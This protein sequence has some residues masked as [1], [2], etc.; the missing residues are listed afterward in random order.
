VSVSLAACKGSPAPPT[1]DVP[2]QDT[3]D[4]G[5][6]FDPDEV[7]PSAAFTDFQA[8]STSDVQGF[9]EHNPYNGGS[10]LSTYQS[11]GVLFS[12]AVT[13]AA[14]TYR[15]NP[16]VLLVAV[17]AEGALVAD[18]A[19]P[20]G[21]VLVD[22][23]FGCGCG[24]PSVASTCAPSAAGLDVQLACYADALRTSLD[25]IA[26]TGQTTGGWGPGKSAT[27][28]DG[29]T[30]Q[31]M[32]DSTAALYQYDPVVGKG[33]TGNS[34][35]AN[36]W[37]E[38]AES[39]SYGIPGGPTGATAMVGDACVGASD[40]A[41]PDAI[42]ATGAG[43]PGGMC[44]SRCSGSCPGVDAF[45]ADFTKGG[46]CLAV[47]S[48]DDSWSCRTGYTCALVQPSGGPAGAGPEDVCVPM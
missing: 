45:C 14:T 1:L 28:L 25:Q 22:Y 7:V 32:D 24:V 15:I 31:P 47:C 21:G 30:V 37:I 35:F 9:L 17:E 3:A 12:A 11:N 8:E 41:V 19:Y 40:C 20:Q 2:P 23:L 6:P 34:L 10:F 39:F 27:T 42:C 33:D 13:N 16:I 4:S 46:Y 26:A 5:V 36:V 44:T 43:Y 48:P 29:V 38:Y 18:P